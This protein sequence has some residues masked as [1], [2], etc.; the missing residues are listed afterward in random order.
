MGFDDSDKKGEMP[1]DISPKWL[2][3]GCVVKS[4]ATVI[5]FD[6]ALSV[7]DK[8]GYGKI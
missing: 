2:Y 7:L 4:I 1:K 6:G 8:A 3:P 5:I